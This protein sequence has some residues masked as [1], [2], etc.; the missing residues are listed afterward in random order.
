M[1]CADCWEWFVQFV[2]RAEMEDDAKMGFDDEEDDGN[3]QQP[4]KATNGALSKNKDNG[5][6]FKKERMKQLFN[7]HG[8]N[9]AIFPGGLVKG[10]VVPLILKLFLLCLINVK[11][12]KWQES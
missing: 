5:K 10:K 8:F 7:K 12:S 9:L 4:D 6:S 3:G 1:S 11:Y 2:I